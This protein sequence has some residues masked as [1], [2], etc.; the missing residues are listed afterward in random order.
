MAKVMETNQNTVKYGLTL[1]EADAQLIVS[2]RGNALKEQ[3]PAD[4]VEQ[5]LKRYNPGYKDMIVWLRIR[6]E[7][8]MDTKRI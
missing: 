5:I 6:M 4:R 2:E 1:S 8:K 3:F 7:G